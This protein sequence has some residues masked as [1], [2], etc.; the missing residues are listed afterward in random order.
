VVTRLFK[1]ST[2]QKPRKKNFLALLFHLKKIA[3]NNQKNFNPE[4]DNL[5]CKIF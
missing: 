1:Q 3:K 5:G 2:S 4:D